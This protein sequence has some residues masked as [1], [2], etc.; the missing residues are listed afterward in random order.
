MRC[1]LMVRELKPGTFG[2]TGL[3][4]IHGSDPS[5][6]VPR[7]DV[8]TAS[9][10]FDLVEQSVRHPDQFYDACNARVATGTEGP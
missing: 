1:A 8:G 3:A 4:V 7:A 5:I 2:Q 9:G 6:R 10:V